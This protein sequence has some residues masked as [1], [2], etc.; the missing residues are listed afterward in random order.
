MYTTYAPQ[1]VYPTNCT[2]AST[3]CEPKHAGLRT[4]GASPRLSM[5]NIAQ[6][7]CVRTC[8]LRT[9]PRLSIPVH[10]QRAHSKARAYAQSVH[11][12]CCPCQN[13]IQVVQAQCIRAST[14]T[15]VYYVRRPG[16]PC[17]ILTLILLLL[18]AVLNTMVS[19]THCCTAVDVCRLSAAVTH[20]K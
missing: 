10:A 9:P 13:A 12:P 6:A 2:C 3:A 17:H 5:P 15:H 1:S 18:Y 7:Q 11:R 8:T 14:S 19:K 20:T 16:C 4:I